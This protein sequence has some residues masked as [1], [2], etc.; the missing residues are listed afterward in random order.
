M[1]KSNDLRFVLVATQRGL[2]GGSNQYASSSEQNASSRSTHT[3]PLPTPPL[4]LSLALSL[5]LLLL[6]LLLLSIGG[7]AGSD[8]LRGAAPAAPCGAGLTC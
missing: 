1:A 7:R 4:S 2:C 6:L 8:R 5:L 3:H